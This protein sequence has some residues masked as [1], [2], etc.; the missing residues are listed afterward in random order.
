MLGCGSG[1]AEVSP[2][3]FDAT[4]GINLRG[5][6]LSM[7]FEIRELMRQGGGGAIVNTASSAGM[8]GNPGMPS[9][10]ASKWGVIGLTKS[11]AIDYGPNGIRVNAICPFA[12]WTPM[13]ERTV[14]AHPERM[15]W[16]EAMTPLRRLGRGDEIASTVG[17][18][19]SDNSSFVTGHEV[20]VD[21]GFLAG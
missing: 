20:P 19:C 2:S 7:H 11:T 14:A 15:A 3:T 1:V 4:V 10:S 6:F 16:V 9:Y 5:V 21:G 8:R 12:I 17:W 13:M 18:L